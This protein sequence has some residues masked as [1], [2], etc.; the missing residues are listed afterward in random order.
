MR[1]GIFIPAVLTAVSLHG[2]PSRVVAIE[3]PKAALQPLQTIWD[4]CV[5]F[6]NLSSTE[7]TSAFRGNY[8]AG[9]AALVNLD[10]ACVFLRNLSLAEL[11]VA[12]EGRKNQTV[13]MTTPPPSWS[14]PALWVLPVMI[15]AASVCVCMCEICFL[16]SSLATHRISAAVSEVHQDFKSSDVLGLMTSSKNFLQS[17]ALDLHHE[18][19]SLHRSAYS[20]AQDVLRRT[21]MTFPSEGTTSTN[22]LHRAL[23]V[24]LHGV[25][26]ESESSYAHEGNKEIAPQVGADFWD[27]VEADYNARKDAP[28]LPAA[29]PPDVDVVGFWQHDFPAD[30][31][32]EAAK[33]RLFRQGPC[34]EV[35]E[36]KFKSMEG[37][38]SQHKATAGVDFKLI[39][40]VV[41]FEPGE[42]SRWV[43]V[44]L[45]RKVHHNTR[46]FEVQLESVLSGNA[47][48][49]G[50]TVFKFKADDREGT[51]DVAKFARVL[52]LRDPT[53]RYPGN[54]PTTRKS[55]FWLTLYY[56]KEVMQL[57]G[58]K[59][60]KATLGL[61]YWP[62]HTVIVVEATRKWM[63]DWACDPGYINKQYQYL[64]ILVLAAIYMLSALIVRWGDQVQT[65]NRGRTGVRMVHRQRLLT[66]LMSLDYEEQCLA[67]AST[68]FY[69]ALQNVEVLVMDA[70][71]QS[72]Q[73]TQNLL[74]LF[75]SVVFLFL[76]E[77]TPQ[78]FGKGSSGLNQ[79][80]NFTP[81]I[82]LLCIVP[83]SIYV[84][85]RRF[86]STE[87]YFESRMDA[88]EA[89]VETFSW[90]SHLGRSM[91][92][93]GTR[94][95]A[96]LE[97]KFNYESIRFLKRHWIAR[98]Y[99]NDSTWVTRWLAEIAYVSV[100]V[101]GAMKLL[102]Y[103]V[104]KQQVYTTG[105]YT[106]ALSVFLKFGTS[107]VKVNE[108]LISLQKS[109]AS[110]QRVVDMLNLPEHVTM[111][112][113]LAAR[114]KGFKFD[115]EAQASCTDHIAIYGVE[116]KA[117]NFAPMQFPVDK[118]TIVPLGRVVRVVGG[119]QGRAWS[120]M[121]LLAGVLR[122]RSGMI[123]R[124]PSIWA[125][126]STREAAPPGWA[127]HEVLEM[128]GTPTNI[129]KSLAVVLGINPMMRCDQLAPGEMQA[130]SI[131]RLLLRDPDIVLCDKSMTLMTDWARGR[132]TKLLRAWQAG[133][134]IERI[135]SWLLA[136]ESVISC[137]EAEEWV[138]SESDGN[139]HSRIFPGSQVRPRTLVITDRDLMDQWDTDVVLN[140]HMMLVDED[141]CLEV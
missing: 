36:V 125:G 10:T 116:F 132:M 95:L 43:E 51:T 108:S 54:M 101:Y 86:K 1:L 31:N 141:Y 75:L 33:V 66:K 53:L 11:A 39:D 22:K 79:A 85:S 112:M 46:Q 58:L 38:M 60:W 73:L 20:F 34:L 14:A 59:Y 113:E 6:P 138:K 137:L 98:D 17:T 45:A 89:W 81:S 82:A 92:S 93:F 84:M 140:L 80:S 15:L 96:T 121:A 130:V 107:L 52:I 122:P 78:P 67:E 87:Q 71:W 135:L 8:S 76:L 5:Q 136:D 30:A 100:F 49:G 83:L 90:A 56:I 16:K 120:F 123:V 2:P 72:F 18:A 41:R 126:M 57:R 115:E 104:D 21:T 40:I 105:D 134:G 118:A 24:N 109:A 88:E 103:R 9:A 102:T 139:R 13:L 50:S 111:R 119:G 48:L 7:L 106:L 117:A 129:A 64:L 55:P 26:G 27:A 25:Y 97:A 63:I 23:S 28:P 77:A 3:T 47:V 68:W 12:I 114:R 127:V 35:V 99:L 110:I 42:K 133:G 32:D 19:K 29:P 62:F 131:A 65:K 44:P 70:F 69:N 128:L 94:E 37:E 4:V 124:P 74:A 61:C 91:F